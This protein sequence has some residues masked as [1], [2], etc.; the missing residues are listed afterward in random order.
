MPLFLFFLQS[1]NII[2]KSLLKVY[3]VGTAVLI[4]HGKLNTLKGIVN[5]NRKGALNA[6]SSHKRAEGGRS[7][8]VT[9]TVVSNR[10]NIIIVGEI[11]VGSA[12]VCINAY[13]AL[14]ESYTRQSGALC[15]ESAK[16]AEVRDG[17]C[18]GSG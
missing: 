16:V 14:F 5:C 10:L 7:K 11:A 3:T 18:G 9:C 8:D 6:M 2:R 13:L 12:V 1:F 4:L 15:T 17:V